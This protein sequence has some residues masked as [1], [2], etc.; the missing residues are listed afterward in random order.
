MQSLLEGKIRRVSRFFAQT[1]YDRV[2][3]GLVY[4]G[5]FQETLDA[6][7]YTVIAHGHANLRAVEDTTRRLLA[8]MERGPGACDDTASSESN[9]D[10]KKASSSEVAQPTTLSDDVRTTAPISEH[11]RR[12]GHVNLTF[13]MVGGSTLDGQKW[14]VPG[15]RNPEGSRG[16]QSIDIKELDREA[17]ATTLRANPSAGTDVNNLFADGDHR[18]AGASRMWSYLER[19]QKTH[20]VACARYANRVGELVHRNA[21]VEREAATAI[22]LRDEAVSHAKGWETRHRHL[23]ETYA[24]LEGR[25]KAEVAL[26]EAEA[27][28]ERRRAFEA[29]ALWNGALEEAMPWLMQLVAGFAPIETEELGVKLFESLGVD[30]DQY[31]HVIARKRM[32]EVRIVRQHAVFRQR[33]SVNLGVTRDTPGWG[34]Q[35]PVVIDFPSRGSNC[36]CF[37]QSLTCP[38]GRRI[39]NRFTSFRKTVFRAWG[40][41]C[42][43]R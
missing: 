43:G 33:S 10:D 23:E 2:V 30:A 29:T 18:Y 14:A 41:H 16:S 34:A 4:R 26:A 40:A 21:Y 11:N 15:Q 28:R 19:V 36:M 37:D 8:N 6:T 5:A 9:V 38:S 35:F 3:G 24:Q 39:S 1:K 17:A 32:F 12:L 20:N 22:E 27:Q 25:A 13:G 7:L 31:D 42:H